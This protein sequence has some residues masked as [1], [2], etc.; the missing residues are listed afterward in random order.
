M[1]QLQTPG[2]CWASP[3]LGPQGA[4]GPPAGCL[5]LLAGLRVQYRCIQSHCPGQQ[6]AAV[7]QQCQQTFHTEP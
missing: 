6:N 7:L 3:L 4:E 1:L 5:K 2:V